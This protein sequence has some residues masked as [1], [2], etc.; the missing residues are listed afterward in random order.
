MNAMGFGPWKGSSFR[1]ALGMSVRQI[2]GFVQ[3]SRAGKKVNFVGTRE[4]IEKQLKILPRSPVNLPEKIT[5][6]Y[7]IEFP[8]TFVPPNGRQVIFV[9]IPLEVEVRFNDKKV[10]IIGFTKTSFILYGPVDGGIIARRIIGEVIDEKD[11]KKAADGRHMVMPLRIKNY[12]SKIREVTRILINTNYMDLYY[13]EGGRQVMT[14]KIKMDLT[15]R[16]VYVRHLN[17]SHVKG[18]K[19]LSG[20]SQLLKKEERMKM[21]WEEW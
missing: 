2:D 16:G 6:Y 5:D 9:K 15:A 12:T 10:D 4:E 7:M 20:N 3:Y 11:I 17:A 1:K 13:A 14:E 19:K 21:E 18:L 8:K